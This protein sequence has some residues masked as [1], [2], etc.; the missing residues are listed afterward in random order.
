MESFLGLTA[1]VHDKDP[2]KTIADALEI[3]EEMIRNER[4]TKEEYLKAMSIIPTSNEMAADKAAKFA[5]EI[6]KLSVEL[7]N[8]VLPPASIGEFFVHADGTSL[9][10]GGFQ[11]I[12]G[13]RAF[14]KVFEK[15]FQN[16]LL[17]RPSS[18]TPGSMGS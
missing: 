14:K 13:R 18:C 7:R 8:N 9:L 15:R 17:A 4:M 1:K 12:P 3:V 10:N 2:L 11:S 16:T 6:G 5:S